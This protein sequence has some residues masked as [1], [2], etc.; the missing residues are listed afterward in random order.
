[1]VLP[2]PSLPSGSTGAPK[3]AP[4]THTMAVVSGHG[5][6]PL[7]LKTKRAH[8][9]TAGTETPSAPSL[10]AS[11]SAKARSPAE[12]ENR[13]RPTRKTWCTPHVANASA[14]SAEWAVGRS[15]AS[16]R[17]PTSSSASI[18][19]VSSG[20]CLLYISARKPGSSCN[21]FLS[22]VSMVSA[23]AD[24]PAHRNSA[25]TPSNRACNKAFAS[26][27]SSACRDLACKLICNSA[28]S[29]TLRLSSALMLSSSEAFAFNS[30]LASASADRNSAVSRSAAAARSTAL[31]ASMRAAMASSLRTLHGSACFWRAFSSSAPAAAWLRDASPASC[32]RV[33]VTA[34]SFSSHT[35]TIWRAASSV[36]RSM[37]LWHLRCESSVLR[38]ASKAST[39]PCFTCPAPASLSSHA[40]CT[41]QRAENSALRSC[42]LAKNCWTSSASCVSHTGFSRPCLRMSGL[43]RLAS[44]SASSGEPPSR[45][46]SCTA[47]R[48]NT[49]ERLGWDTSSLLKVRTMRGWVGAAVWLVERGSVLC[50]ATSKETAAVAAASSMLT[51]P[52]VPSS[53]SSS[54]YM[55]SAEVFSVTRS[56]TVGAGMD[57]KR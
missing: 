24:S 15:P 2:G 52:R 18:P 12:A 31:A 42:S 9:G 48:C 27:S 3:L 7:F 22:C 45:L 38:D 43:A 47:S 54:A 40:A 56:P 35:R 49:T 34:R 44:R 50:S 32:R 37:G 55:A 19:S 25:E 5:T 21:S 39:L 11:A 57:L 36:T 1:M 26:N 17:K 33:A 23:T 6:S 46:P 30:M 16:P 4:A 41:P 8:T 28:T 13:T 51:P 14:S 20:A 53:K 10:T 29:S